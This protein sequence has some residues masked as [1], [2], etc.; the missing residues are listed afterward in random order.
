MVLEY[1]SDFIF[2][3]YKIKKNWKL[4]WQSQFSKLFN[5]TNLYDYQNSNRLSLWMEFI[6]FFVWLMRKSRC[7]GGAH[8]KWIGLRKYTTL[9]RP[10]DLLSI[11]TL[12][13]P[14]F[15]FRSL[16]AFFWPYCG[17]VEYLWP[18]WAFRCTKFLAPSL[19]IRFF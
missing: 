13:F 1:R 4:D 16:V 7:L 3:G 9:S 10:C 6:S 15:F 8:E 2:I 18:Y 5:G 14:L 17:F 12:F 11:C 19:K